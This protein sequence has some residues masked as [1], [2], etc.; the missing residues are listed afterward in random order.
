[1][2]WFIVYLG[3]DDVTVN[4]CPVGHYCPDASEPYLCPPGTRRPV[5]GAADPDI[6]CW[7]C[8]DGYYCPNDTINTIGIPCEE[9]YECPNGTAIPVDCRGGRYCPPMTGEGLPCPGGYHCPPFTGA[10]P[11]RCYYP[12]YCPPMSEVE[13]LCPLGYMAV[14]HNGIRELVTRSCLICPGGTYGNHTERLDCQPC[15]EAFYCP[16]GTTYG[17]ENPCTTGSYCP[18]NSSAPLPCP[19]GSYGKWWKATSQ[20]Q[21]VPCPPGHYSDVEGMTK[22]KQCG[23]SSSSERGAVSC[24]CIGKYRSFHKSDGAC[25]CKSNYYY[26]DETQ[27]SRTDD[28]GIGD[29]Q[30]ITRDLCTPG[31]VRMQ[32]T[33]SCVLPDAVQSVCDSVCRPNGQDSNG[34]QSQGALDTNTG[35]YVLL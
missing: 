22:C 17:F 32:S 28:D 20:S 5:P 27:R 3:M 11:I 15:P 26:F 31:Q 30:Q 9:H 7:D 24:N 10:S 8:P 2:T 29:C 16:E 1:M 23:S 4:P 25:R 18:A 12:Y 19:R 21:C 13:Q 14:A 33:S 34:Q 6:D 35:R